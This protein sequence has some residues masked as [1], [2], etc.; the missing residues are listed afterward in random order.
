MNE[1]KIC[2]PLSIS[3]LFQVKRAVQQTGYLRSKRGYKPLNGVLL[4]DIKLK[5]PELVDLLNDEKDYQIPHN[6][7][8]TDPLF[9]K[10]WFLVSFS[11]LI[12]QIEYEPAHEIMVLF[13]LRKFI[14]EIRM[15]SHPVGLDVCFLVWPFVYFHTSCVW[16]AKGLAR[17]HGCAGSPEP[18][19]VAYEISTILSWAASFCSETSWSKPT[20]FG[21]A[22]TA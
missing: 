1:N 12:Y 3:S 2:S 4:S 13:V 11:I 6:L 14:L 21:N 16:T 19:L 5:S 20:L 8:P 7:D 17:L 9:P 15:R 22:T 10:E 18:S